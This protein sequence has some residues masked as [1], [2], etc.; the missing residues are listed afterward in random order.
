MYAELV[1]YKYPSKLIYICPSSPDEAEYAD[2]LPI[3][4]ASAICVSLNSQYFHVESIVLMDGVRTF[5][6]KICK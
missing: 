3:K 6:Y 4:R 1:T 5:E 2:I